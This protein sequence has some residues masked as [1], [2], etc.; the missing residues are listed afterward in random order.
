[1]DGPTGALKTA[2]VGRDSFGLIA[3]TNLRLPRGK[4][5]ITTLSDDGI[6]VTADGNKII[7]RWTHHGPEKDTAVIDLKDD[8]TVPIRVEYFELDGYAVLT[9]GIEKVAEGN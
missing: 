4:W 1:M 8:R 7:E 3:D 5:K 2:D 6:R 9:L